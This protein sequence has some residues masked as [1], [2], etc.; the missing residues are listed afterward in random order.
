MSLLPLIAATVTLCQVCGREVRPL[1]L[2]ESRAGVLGHRSCL[3]AAPDTKPATIT[4]GP[5]DDLGRPLE[6]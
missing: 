3:E 5:A 2:W 4:L 1:S 6:P